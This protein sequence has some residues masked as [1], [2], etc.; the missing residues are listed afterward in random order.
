MQLQKLFELIVIAIWLLNDEL[1][2]VMAKKYGLDSL[3]TVFSSN[4]E[5]IEFIS[6]FFLKISL[7][8]IKKSHYKQSIFLIGYKNLAVDFLKEVWYT[9]KAI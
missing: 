4:S 2:Y 6:Y 1:K 9:L 3:F 8:P 7:C 5:N